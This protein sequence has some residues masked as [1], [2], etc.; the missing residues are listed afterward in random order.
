MKRKCG[1]ILAVLAVGGT[2]SFALCTRAQINTPAE[3]H[4]GATLK[5][6]TNDTA[7]TAKAQAALAR[8]KGTSDAADLST[9]RPMAGW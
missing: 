3:T 4:S 7:V 6:E 8:D 5:D 1:F 9:C 2:L